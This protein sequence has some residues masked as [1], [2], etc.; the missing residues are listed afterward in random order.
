MT[1]YLRITLKKPLQNKTAQNQAIV[2]RTNWLGNLTVS[3]SV[4][5]F[6]SPFLLFVGLEP[7]Q[8]TKGIEMIKATNQ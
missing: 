2:D 3:L 4:V 1:R 5:Y 7:A 6:C 8:N